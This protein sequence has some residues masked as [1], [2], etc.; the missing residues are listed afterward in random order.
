MTSSG[1]ATRFDN[2]IIIAVDP[3]GCM[4]WAG[5]EPP[6]AFML[7]LTERLRP[8]GPSW[9]EWFDGLLFVLVTREP[10]Y[11]WEPR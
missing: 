3:H 4:H 11:D 7:E 9:T 1:L 2:S 6:S 10:L 5:D 8:L